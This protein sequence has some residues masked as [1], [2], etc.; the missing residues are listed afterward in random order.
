MGLRGG[1]AHAARVSFFHSMLLFGRDGGFAGETGC[2]VTSV[3]VRV[4]HQME[5]RG[6]EGGEGHVRVSGR[7]CVCFGHG[8][9][10]DVVG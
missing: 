2:E 10:Q 1:G 8:T 5:G 6:G 3:G 4:S 9:G 7:V